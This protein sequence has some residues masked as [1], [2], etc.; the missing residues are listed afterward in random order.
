M[1]TRYVDVEGRKIAVS[2]RED[3]A[4]RRGAQSD[5]FLA[6][7]EKQAPGGPGYPV[8]EEIRPIFDAFMEIMTSGHEGVKLALTQNIYMFLGAVR[9]AQ[10]VTKLEKDVEEI[11]RVIGPREDDFKTSGS[12]G[13]KKQRAGGQ[14]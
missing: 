7:R 11:K 5:T 10:K 3:S 1:T 14:N 8:P 2:S 12:K 6:E 4:E 13:E 9:N